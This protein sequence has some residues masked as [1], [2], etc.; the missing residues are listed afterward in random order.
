MRSAAQIV[1]T[2][3]SRYRWI[4]VDPNSSPKRPETLPKAIL[5]KG[6]YEESDWMGGRRRKELGV[7][8]R[9][10]TILV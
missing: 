2:V 4:S 3:P 1:S 9:S 6:R 7:A 5:P 8:A 10:L